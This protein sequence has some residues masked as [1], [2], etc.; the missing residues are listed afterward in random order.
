MYQYEALV[1]VRTQEAEREA[2]RQRMVREVTAGRQWSR[3]ARFAAK[4]AEHARRRL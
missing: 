3:L 1:R 2:R 4:R